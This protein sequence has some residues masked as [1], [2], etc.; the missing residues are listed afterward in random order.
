MRRWLRGTEVSSRRSSK[1]VER[2]GKV[3]MASRLVEVLEVWKEEEPKGH[4]IL[5]PRSSSI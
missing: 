3:E 4:P 2:G 1:E 5:K